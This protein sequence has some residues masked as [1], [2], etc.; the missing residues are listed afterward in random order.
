M[1]VDP[2]K[3]AIRVNAYMKKPE[4]E[5]IWAELETPIWAGALVS[6]ITF[7]VG[8]VKLV[9]IIWAI[10][11]CKMIYSALTLEAVRGCRSKA[12]QDPSL[13]AG[14]VCHGVITN[15]NIN[16]GTVLGSLDLA[17]DHDRL[18]STAKHLAE[19]YKAQSTSSADPQIVSLLKDDQYQPYR[20]RLIPERFCKT[21]ECYLFDVTL[22]PADGAISEQGTVLYAFVTTKDEAQLIEQL[23]W[24]VAAPCVS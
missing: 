5:K 24:S 9:S 18:A 19:I 4:S 21:K 14:L 2:K 23:P 8:A 1:R 10:N 17:A 12:R 3:L 22:N 20:R 7:V 15:P 6:G 11:G 16:V 13:L